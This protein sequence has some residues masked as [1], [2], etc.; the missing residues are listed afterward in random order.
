M[1]YHKV[2]F[3]DIVCILYSIFFFSEANYDKRSYDERMLVEVTVTRRKSSLS[4]AGGGDKPP[5][6]LEKKAL[7]FPYFPPK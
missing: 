2:Y 7:D 4:L 5:V 6:N 1:I 3:T